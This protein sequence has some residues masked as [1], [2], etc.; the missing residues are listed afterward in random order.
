MVYDGTVTM[1]TILITGATGYVGRRL[2]DRLLKRD[3]LTIRLLVRNKRKLRPS[4]FDKVEVVEGDT[5]NK[6]ALQ[7]ALYG[8]DVAYY[9][10]HSMGAG[11]DFEER[12]RRSAE[13]FRNACLK[14]NV[15]RIIYL[16]GLGVKERERQPTS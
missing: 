15:K 2:K 5:Y 12:D 3:D 11:R 7:K 4:I 10:I 1:K 14:N 8:V 9:L 16:G 6:D 13:N